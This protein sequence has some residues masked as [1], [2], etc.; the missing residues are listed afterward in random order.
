MGA[1]FLRDVHG[2]ND[3]GNWLGI[4]AHGIPD[5][6]EYKISGCFDLTTYDR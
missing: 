2:F 3:D 6:K 1:V 4:G 5:Y